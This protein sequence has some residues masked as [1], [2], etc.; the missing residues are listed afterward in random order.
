VPGGAAW[1]QT[2]FYPFLHAATY[3]R[4]ISL[5]PAVT[6]EKYDSR[7]YS[8]IPYVETAAVYDEGTGEV[9]VFA[10]NRNLAE[11]IRLDVDL[12]DFGALRVLEHLAMH[13]A[14]LK[15][16]NGPGKE[17][18]APKTVSGAKISGTALAVQL[19]AASWNVIR[20]GP[21]K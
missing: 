7:E 21:A 16:V 18:V 15:A 19:P 2:I 20:L 14:D 11:P 12:L 5:R 17:T 8:D 6:C 3:G 10:V 13:N 4:G 9:T 1:R